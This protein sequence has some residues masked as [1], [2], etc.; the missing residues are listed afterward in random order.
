MN[1]K[2]ENGGLEMIDVKIMQDSFLCQWLLKLANASDAC[3]W[4]WIPASVFKLFGNDYACFNTTICIGTTKFK[5]LNLINSVFWKA[6]VTT[7]LRC[8]QCSTESS[9][10]TCLWNN[11]KILYQNNALYFQTWAQGGFTYVSDMLCDGVILPFITIETILGRSPNLFLEYIVVSSAVASYLKLN[12]LQ[13]GNKFPLHFNGEKNTTAKVIR[14]FIVDLKYST[15]CAVKFWKN[16]FNIN[17]DKT[18]WNI[19]KCVTAES[20]LR[21][22]HWKIVH[23]IY[24]TNILLKKMGLVNSEY[25]PNCFN[26]IDFI[27]H[28]F[29][30]CDKIRPL[31]KYIENIIK[32]RF[33]C[34]VQ[35]DARSVLLAF[36]GLN[37]TLRKFINHAILIGKM[38]ISKFRYGTPYNIIFIFE[39]EAALRHLLL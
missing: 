17:I 10:N 20:R 6:V 36:F 16:K 11:C 12:P 14:A 30:F 34:A 2:F 33:S 25:C 37:K 5:G 15:P 4:T 38:C 27:E 22:L 26:E 19:S 31:W 35:L 18:C 39:R 1:S 32:S 24:P 3:K 28:F 13:S 8:N 23:N 21:E 9:R 7:W 29:Y